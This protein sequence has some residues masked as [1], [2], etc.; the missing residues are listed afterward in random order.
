MSLTVPHRY[1]EQVLVFNG[2]IITALQ[3]QFLVT[4]S[5]DGVSGS[6][7]I[8]GPADNVRRCYD[9]VSFMLKSWIQWDKQPTDTTPLHTQDPPLS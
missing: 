2:C 4:V 1:R 6:M 3:E 9:D 8:R 7:S 5:Y